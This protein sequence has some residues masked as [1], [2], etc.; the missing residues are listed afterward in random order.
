M[1][2]YNAISMYILLKMTLYL[3]TY[4]LRKCCFADVQISLCFYS[5][6]N[7]SLLL[8]RSALKHTFLI[9][10]KYCTFTH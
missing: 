5:D 4:Y 10:Q 6:N 1:S 8:C 3:F 7:D 9:Y 2:F